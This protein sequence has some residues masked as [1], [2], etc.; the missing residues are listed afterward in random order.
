MA[1]AGEGGGVVREAERGGKRLLIGLGIFLLAT[2]VVCVPVGML[3]SSNLVWGESDQ[4]GRV[5]VPGRATLDL[6]ARTIDVEIALDIVGKGNE[7]VEVPLPPN[8]ALTVTPTGDQPAPSVVRDV[9]DSG[10]TNDNG[11]NSQRRVFRVDVAEAGSYDV[12]A[13][14]NFRG[15]GINA[16]FWFGHGPPIPG[17][18]VPLIAAGLVAIGFLVW[19]VLL[20][21]IRRARSSSF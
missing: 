10:N 16:Q 19:L 1:D 3:G 8:L 15:V 12:V 6:P 4:Y 5:D 21:R 9:G 7:T 2:L 13:R 17:T 11:T 14:G 20:P 18:L